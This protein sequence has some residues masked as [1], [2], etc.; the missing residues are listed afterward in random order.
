MRLSKS[1]ENG[2]VLAV[3]IAAV[4][5]ATIIAVSY[6]LFANDRRERVGRILDQAAKEMALEGVVLQAKAKIEN[7]VL[8]YGTLALPEAQKLELDDQ[9]TISLRLSV[10][11]HTEATAQIPALASLETGSGNLSVTLQESAG[12]PFAGAQAQVTRVAVD[13]QVSDSAMASART[14]NKRVTASP[15]IDIRQIP[16]SEFTIYS[17]GSALELNQSN[18]PDNLGRVFAEGSITVHG[19]ILSY[20]PLVSAQNVDT[21]DTGIVTF[22]GQAKD[23]IYLGPSSGS[24]AS[25]SGWI[26]DARTKYDSKIIT[27][28]VLPVDTAPAFGIYVDSDGVAT[29]QGGQLNLDALRRACALEIRAVRDP[30]RRTRQYSITARWVQTNELA[31][32][33]VF[34]SVSPGRSSQ[35]VGNETQRGSMGGGTPL[36]AAVP[37]FVVGSGAGDS[38]FLAI[39]YATLLEKP[40][41]NSIYFEVD[42]GTGRPVPAA[43]LVIRSAEALNDS[44]SIVTPHHIAVEGNFNVSSS[45]TVAASLITPQDIRAFA[46]GYFNAQLGPAK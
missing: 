24:S 44:L 23:K 7:E 26:N 33:F 43:W 38:V 29:A 25:Q 18:F 21:G 19:S 36:G 6:L 30:R 13:A 40:P 32:I 8:Q 5:I 34:K 15:E 2:S 27:P 4:S 35:S 42:D 22:A 1:S 37:N 46:A 28:A 11:G 12:D 20:Y 39:N 45:R 16:V 10:E 9:S 41:L 3:V 14:T 31:T 17:A